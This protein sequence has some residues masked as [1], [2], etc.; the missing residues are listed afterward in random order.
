MISTPCT[1]ACSM[2]CD[3]F[4]P[5]DSRCASRAPA[6]VSLFTYGNGTFVI[7]SY[8]NHPVAVRV[9]GRLAQI[10]SLARGT[11][12][13]GD[14]VRSAIPIARHTSAPK[15]YGYELR[16]EPHSFIGIRECT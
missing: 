6:G 7:D 1:R 11:V 14:P 15:R 8:R 4:S 10:E 12:L 2:G 3:A 5:R 9:I 16:I 13:G